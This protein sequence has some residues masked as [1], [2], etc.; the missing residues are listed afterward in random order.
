MID[1]FVLCLAFNFLSIQNQIDL[2]N[3]GLRTVCK[4]SHYLADIQKEY[5]IN[6]F[7]YAALIYN[8]SRWIP[9]A[10]S[11]KGACGLTQ[12]LPKYT[13]NNCNE[14]K[15]PHT[16]MREGAKKLAYWKKY[17]KGSIFKALNCYS[18]GYK[19][20]NPAYSKRVLKI[21]KRLKKQYNRIIERI[22]N[23]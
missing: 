1:G 11:H 8:E 5:N 14:L 6:P 21:S 3:L 18:S 13:K 22:L 23:E 9:T 7:V 10:I 4:N 2:T 20:N 19:C 17:K 15:D 16:S 12:V